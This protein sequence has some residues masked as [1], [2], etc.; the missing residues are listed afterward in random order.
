MGQMPQGQM[1]GNNSWQDPMAN[2]SGMSDDMMKSFENMFRTLKSA[3]NQAQ[4]LQMLAKVNP[5]FR[6]V[7]NMCN[8]RDPKEV[9]LQ[10]CQARGIDVQYA[11][12]TL[13]RMGMF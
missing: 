13:S 6:E 11:F 8:G 10:E 9:F 4:A 12:Q 3:P 1:L 5:Q 7:V 2:S